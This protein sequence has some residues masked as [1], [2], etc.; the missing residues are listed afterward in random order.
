MRQCVSAFGTGATAALG[1]LNPASF[2]VPTTAA[3]TITVSVYANE[4]ASGVGV[5]TLLQTIT[6]IVTGSTTYANAVLTND[7]ASNVLGT[8]VANP[9]AT[10]VA[11]NGN[12]TAYAVSTN[13]TLAE[14]VSLALKGTDGNPLTSPAPAV[15]WSLSGVGYL[16][17]GRSYVATAA[18]GGT[19]QTMGIYADGRTGTAVVTVSVNGT[20]VGTSTVV[21]YSTKVASLVATANYTVA[22]AANAAVVGTNPSS[23]ITSAHASTE[24]S[25]SWYSSYLRCC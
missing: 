24:P 8:Y 1:A 20:A 15:T 19:P 10:G 18:G 6:I 13:G 14:T 4:I 25:N 5:Q 23:V 9:S 16:T 11:A 12:Q 22:A 21:F 2:K 7:A 17:G 3:G